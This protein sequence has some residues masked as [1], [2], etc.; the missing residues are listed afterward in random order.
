MFAQSLPALNAT[1]SKK[2][3][4]ERSLRAGIVQR[5]DYHRQMSEIESEAR[6]GPDYV[7]V[8]QKSK[9]GAMVAD[10]STLWKVMSTGYTSEKHAMKSASAVVHGDNQGEWAWNQVGCKKYK[11]CNFHVNCPVLLRPV[12]NATG[13]CWR[14]EVT[15]ASHAL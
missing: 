4:L 2:E 5:P 9:G 7:E 14:L 15:D 3:L 11:R 10:F 12:S 6:G 1:D 13:D 8:P